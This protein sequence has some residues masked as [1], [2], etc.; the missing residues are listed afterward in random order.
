[1]KLDLVLCL[2][3]AAYAAPVPRVQKA[4]Q[5]A[6][7][8][9]Q[10]AVAS[11]ADYLNRKL[12]L[13]VHDAVRRRTK[14]HK[15]YGSKEALMLKGITEKQSRAAKIA[16]MRKALENHIKEVADL[17]A[18]VS[19]LSSMKKMVD[20]GNKAWQKWRQQYIEKTGKLPEIN[21]VLG[22][23]QKELDLAERNLKNHRKQTKNELALL[24]DAR[25]KLELAERNL[26]NQ[27]TRKAV[28]RTTAAIGAIGAV[29]I[30][31]DSVNRETPDDSFDPL[32]PHYEPAEPVEESVQQP[33]KLPVEQPV[34]HVKE[35]VK[36]VKEPGV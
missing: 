15:G 17:R 13:A 19:E 7:H 31:H 32:D 29:V 6:G 25:K 12:R 18:E 11:G 34:K 27:K 2:A 30:A 8:G 14:W 21:E 9:V 28:L 33:D 10:K 22:L 16:D 26:K 3:T 20:F 24:A 23:A 36:H 1:M 5:G 4:V 35:P